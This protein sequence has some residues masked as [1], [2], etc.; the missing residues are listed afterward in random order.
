VRLPR[1]AKPAE[2]ACWVHDERGLKSTQRATPRDLVRGHVGMKT[3]ARPRDKA[4][5]LTRLRRLSP[6]SVRRWGRM[7]V[8]QMVCHLSDSY[9]MAT[10]DKAVSHCGGFR[11]QTV[12]K[13]M[14][15]YLPLH[16]PPGILTSPEIDQ[17]T[18]GTK[19]I[20]FAA[21]LARLET[22]VETFA[23]QPAGFTWPAHPIFGRMSRAAWLR[24]AY[25]HTDH[26]LRQ[27]GV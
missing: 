22:L 1:S 21:D 19:P 16:W 15:L 12:I 17:E 27:F 2:I 26:H 9:L 5:I 7:S 6:N 18:A 11:E 13:W 14:A 4:E 10:G 8:H 25:L 23:S 3:L 24:W 20:E